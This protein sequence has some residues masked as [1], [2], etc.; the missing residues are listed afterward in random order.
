MN[1]AL[2]CGTSSRWALRTTCRPKSGKGASTS[3]ADAPRHRAE[4]L[5]TVCASGLLRP[6]V[7]TPDRHAATG[8]VT[9]LMVRHRVVM[10]RYDEKSDVWALGCILYELACTAD[11]PLSLEL[12]TKALTVACAITPSQLLPEKWLIDALH[13][14]LTTPF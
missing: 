8:L 9:T 5:G 3:R 12:S 11:A 4:S 13:T 14:S 2:I 7:A 6:A 10:I 1:V